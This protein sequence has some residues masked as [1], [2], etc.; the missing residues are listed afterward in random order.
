MIF[1]ARFMGAVT[2]HFYVSRKLG[3]TLAHNKKDLELTQSRTSIYENKPQ[4][5]QLKRNSSS[6]TLFAGF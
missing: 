1:F 4:I 5:E 6:Q 3:Q 2:I